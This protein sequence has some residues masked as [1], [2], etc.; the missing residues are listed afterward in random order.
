MKPERH[1][2]SCH[3]GQIRFE[4]VI[5]DWVGIRCNCSICTQ[6]G[7]WHLIVPPEQFTLLQGENALSTYRFNTGTARHHFCNCCEIHPFYRPRSH[8]DWYDVNINCLS[9][10]LRS[11]FTVQAFDGQNWEEHIDEIRE[12]P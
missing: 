1:Q 2:G 11:R 8:P 9:S 5:T 10:T 7:F 12:M 6:K 3:C 4:V